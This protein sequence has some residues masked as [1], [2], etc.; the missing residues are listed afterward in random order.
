[1]LPF[2]Q[3]GSGV[4]SANQPADGGHR[5]AGQPRERGADRERERELRHAK[6]AAE[7]ERAERAARLAA[8]EGNGTGSAVLPT[9]SS[10]AHLRGNDRDRRNGDGNPTTS[11][12]VALFQKSNQDLPH[13]YGRTSGVAVDRLDRSGQFS[14]NSQAKPQPSP[15]MGGAGVAAE[16]REHEAVGQDPHQA[17]F[18]FARVFCGCFK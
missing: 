9:T 13:P 4:L 6:R 3:S 18:S 11:S 7:A 10:A 14:P 5:R 1:M 15:L 16:Q 8:S 2:L 17:G 12:N